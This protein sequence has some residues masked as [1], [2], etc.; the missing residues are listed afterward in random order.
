MGKCG[1]THPWAGPHLTF[2]AFYSSAL[3]SE[4]VPRNLIFLFLTYVSIISSTYTSNGLLRV[5]V[6]YQ[7]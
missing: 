5:L 2:P 7:N 6:D 4:G 1:P 3:L